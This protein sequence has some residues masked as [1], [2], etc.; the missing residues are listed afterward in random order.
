MGAVLLFGATESLLQRWSSYVMCNDVH[1][2]VL[3]GSRVETVKRVKSANSSRVIL[4]DGVSDFRASVCFVS[5]SKSQLA[6]HRIPWRLWWDEVVWTHT[7]I[8]QYRWN[9]Y[10]H[11]WW[12][13]GMHAYGDL[14]I[15]IPVWYS[16][17]LTLFEIL[18]SCKAPT[19]QLHATISSLIDSRR[20]CLHLW[21]VVT[22]S[23]SQLQDT[24]TPI[25]FNWVCRLR[26]SDLTPNCSLFVKKCSGSFHSKP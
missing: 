6:F 22:K 8:I 16:F 7:S 10:V 23:T 17:G 15:I 25:K 13:V 5:S 1:V 18:A 21:W 11:A 24:T 4:R 12:H 20:A 19:A 26:G 9:D 3:P 2:E 14:T